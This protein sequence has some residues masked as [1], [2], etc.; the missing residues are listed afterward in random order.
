MTKAELEERDRLIAEKGLIIVGE[1]VPPSEDGT[2]QP[3]KKTLVSAENAQLLESAGDGSLGKPIVQVFQNVI[4]WIYVLPDVRLAKFAKEKS[5]LQDQISHLKLELE[6]EKNRRR[7]HSSTGLLNGPS[8]DYDNDDIQSKELFYIKRRI[9]N[10]DNFTGEA[11]KQ[12]ADYKFRAQKAE[13]DV[14]TLQATV[15]RLESQVIRYKTAAEVSEQSEEA[16]KAEKRKL[17]R[18]VS[19]FSIRINSLFFFF[20]YH[21][22]LFYLVLRSLA[23]LFWLILVAGFKFFNRFF[24]RCVRK[25]VDIW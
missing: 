11:S 17:Q 7:K 8:S 5:E 14:A 24:Y 9:P 18:E 16:L 4:I 3:P 2:L 13:Q 1:E 23:H 21:I 25:P 6:E 12:L 15:A 20:C 10:E 22:I 19:V